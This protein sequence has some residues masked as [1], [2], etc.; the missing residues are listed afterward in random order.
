MNVER[1]YSHSIFSLISSYVLSSSTILNQVACPHQTQIECP[2]WVSGFF[3]NCHRKWLNELTISG[4]TIYF[5]TR[6]WGTFWSPK[7]LKKERDT[8]EAGR[9]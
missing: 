5:K 3:L 1:K 7:C 2:Y 6:L 8:E 9:A 4:N